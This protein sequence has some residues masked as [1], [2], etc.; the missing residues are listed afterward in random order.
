MP[1][2]AASNV[3]P[4]STY[5][6]ADRDS[7]NTEVKR[8]MGNPVTHVAIQESRRTKRKR[9][10]HV[11]YIQGTNIVIYNRSR[12]GVY[13]MRIAIRPQN[14]QNYY[15]AFV[16]EPQTDEEKAWLERYDYVLTTN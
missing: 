16:L 14:V 15:E 13:F 4:E 3:K 2:F 6:L 5:F 10:V 12:D 11:Y 1:P 8:I 7:W 9:T